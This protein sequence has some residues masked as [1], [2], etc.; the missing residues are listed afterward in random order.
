MVYGALVAIAAARRRETE[1]TPA[2]GSREIGREP[3]PITYPPPD[4]SG[5]G[6]GESRAAPQV[7]PDKRPREQFENDQPISAQLS[8]AK[9]QGRGRHAVAPW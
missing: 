5:E 1:R 9:E 8:R 3:Y 2:S 7:D 6:P 4:E